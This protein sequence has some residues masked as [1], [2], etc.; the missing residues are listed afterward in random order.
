MIPSPLVQSYALV[1]VACRNSL[2][3]KAVSAQARTICGRSPADLIGTPLTGLLPAA[4]LDAIPVHDLADW[5]VPVKL[6]RQAGWREANYQALFYPADDEWVVE[7]EP[8]RTWPQ[9]RDYAFRL[10]AFTERLTSATS[11]K[12]LLQAL[13]DG[14]HG[15]L[16]FDRSMVLRFDQSYDGVVVNECHRDGLPTFL[17]VHFTRHD[18]PESAHRKLVANPVEVFTLDGGNVAIRGSFGKAAEQLLRHHVGSREP[19]VNTEKFLDDNK[20]ATNAVLAISRGNQLWGA[21]YMHGVEP[22]RLDYQMRTFLY[23]AGK[24]VEQRI[25][26]FAYQPAR[27]RDH[28]AKD[29]G[30]RLYDNILRSDTLV[31][32]LIGPDFSLLDLIPDTHGAA[33]CSGASLTLHELTP[34]REVVEDIVGWLK[35]EGLTTPFYGTDQLATFYPGGEDLLDVAA[36]ILFLPLDALADNWIIWFRPAAVQSV[37]YGSSPESDVEKARRFARQEVLRYNRSRKWSEASIGNAKKLQNFIRD[38]VM[39]RYDRAQQQNA[40]LQEAYSDLEIFSYAVGHDLRAPLRGIASYADILNEDFG[41]SLGELG[42]HHLQNI[43]DNAVRVQH[44]IRE[45]LALSRIERTKILVNRLTVSRL[46]AESIANMAD[47]SA[48]FLHCEVQPDM[49]DIFGD[50]NYLL[51]VFT[52]LLS[53]AF[54]Y[55]AATKCGRRV[56]VGWTGEYRR[57]HPVFYVEDNGIGIPREQQSRMFNLFTRSTNVEN[58]EGT[59]IGLALVKRI[60]RFHEGEVWI[61]SEENK[62]TRVLFYT[63]VSDP[64]SLYSKYGED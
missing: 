48:K 58:I 47:G 51:M 2:S 28:P 20:L 59:G 4:C 3:I 34:D 37:V 45:I 41:E 42:R 52:N 14:A 9:P 62:G 18:I 64:D 26:H 44:F 50:R 43:K 13:C 21:L 17:G 8:R 54:K 1:I 10:R 53:N 27:H 56:Q 11:K 39:K 5:P 55:S 19:N 40:L 7:I 25:E 22:V 31:Q 32:G 23:L 60:I 16:G 36:G 12:A 33:I 49:P 24:T 46:V 35:R 30:S 57:Q 61:E 63:A 15:H 29:G 38:T 6:P